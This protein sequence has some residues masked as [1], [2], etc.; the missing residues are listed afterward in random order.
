M[1][2]GKDWGLIK[3][4]NFVT[5]FVVE[6]KHWS[7]ERLFLIGQGWFLEWILLQVIITGLPCSARNQTSLGLTVSFPHRVLCFALFRNAASVPEL[8]TASG[9]PVSSLHS[10][11]VAEVGECPALTQKQLRV[12]CVSIGSER[13]LQL[14][15]AKVGEGSG[16]IRIT[17]DSAGWLD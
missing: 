2:I 8:G 7:L 11:D 12:F 4:R 6:L 13:A 1:H 10:Q 16:E 9:L 14:D 15:R 3:E 5:P 17:M